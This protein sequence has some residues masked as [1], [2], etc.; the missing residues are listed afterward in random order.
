M[1]TLLESPFPALVGGVLLTVM[2]AAGWL[3]TGRR[4]LVFL[5]V[6]VALLAGGLVV[7]ERMVVTDRELLEQTLHEIARDVERG[8][9][10]TILEHFHPEAEE[11]KREAAAELPSYRIQSIRIKR[12]IEIEL[13]P[14][15]DP[16]E[17]QVDFNVV[18]TG[19]DA[20]GVI[21]E[22][23]VPRFVS[24][25]FWKDGDRWRVRSYRHA[26]PL[27]GLRIRNEPQP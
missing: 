10:E 5:A 21:G 7:V 16:P 13:R 27:E 23:Q 4:S 26:E 22:R 19:S 12:G 14:K 24:V 25:R 17:A 11:A 9:I 20:G 18:V 3:K 2:L 1:T 15:H 6:L 8:R